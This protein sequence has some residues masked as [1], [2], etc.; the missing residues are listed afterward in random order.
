MKLMR[1]T[2][3][4][5]SMRNIQKKPTFICLSEQYTAIYFSQRIQSCFYS[6]QPQNMTFVLGSRV[7][8]I[9]MGDDGAVQHCAGPPTY[10]FLGVSYYRVGNFRFEPWWPCNDLPFSTT[11][12]WESSC[13]K[14]V[15]TMLNVTEV[16]TFTVSLKCQYVNY[17][18]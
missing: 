9:V 11:D 15:K 16:N 2:G 7:I 3:M 8:W 5:K 14:L 13:A 12:P 17:Q 18:S 1:M 4:M 6:C 10:I